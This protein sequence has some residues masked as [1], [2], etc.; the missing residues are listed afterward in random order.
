MSQEKGEGGVSHHWKTH[1]AGNVGKKGRRSRIPP[2]RG[3]FLKMMK[4]TELNSYGPKC[5]CACH[6]HGQL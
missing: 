6:G 5:S 3:S 2:N 1:D 4:Q